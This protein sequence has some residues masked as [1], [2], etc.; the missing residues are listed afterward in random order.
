MNAGKLLKNAAEIIHPVMV[1][2]LLIPTAYLF[3]QQRTDSYTVLL[4][5][6]G[7]SLVVCSAAAW[8]AARKASGLMTYLAAALFAACLSVHLGQRLVR[9]V[10]DAT[11]KILFSVEL[12]AGCLWLIFAFARV[13]MREKG[14]KKALEENDISWR[15]F[16]VA[17]EHPSIFGFLF[18]AA[19]Y[20]LALVNHCPVFCDAALAG[21]FVYLLLYLAYRHVTVTEEFFS[22]TRE[23]TNVPG[24]KIRTLRGR[25]FAALFVLICLVSLPAFFTGGL[26]KYHDLRFYDF[27]H[28]IDSEDF[29]NITPEDASDIDISDWELEKPEAFVPPAWLI[30]LL[31]ILEKILAIL[32]MLVSAAMLLRGIIRYAR[33][34]HGAVVEENEDIAVSLRQDDFQKNGGIFRLKQFRALTEREKI[35]RDY[36]RAIL[37]YRRRGQEPGKSETPAQIEA[38]TK[39][40]QGYDVEKLHETYELA[41]YG[42]SEEKKN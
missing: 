3:D 42:K 34:F 16:G 24:K 17:L 41:R 9:G 22:Q 10:S 38:G 23:M 6:A 14:R 37:K 25:R 1:L 13:R 2:S 18:F 12:I 33:G 20:V 27:S 26:R 32:V 29:R 31:R 4:Y 19:A 28:V 21:A 40:P 30:I 8:A 7:L 35:K 5:A 39:F 36:R 11:L 15:E